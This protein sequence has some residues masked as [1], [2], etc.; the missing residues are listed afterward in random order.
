M[1]NKNKLFK[2]LFGLFFSISFSAF[3]AQPKGDPQSEDDAQRARVRALLAR[4]KAIRA[5]VAGL[6]L[7]RTQPKAF[8]V[9]VIT[10]PAT[11]QGRKNTG[12]SPVALRAE[13]SR[14]DEPIFAE[15]QQ[16]Q[17]PE[18]LVEGLEEPIAVS[19]AGF[20][21]ADQ[22][23]RSI[24]GSFE[25]PKRALVDYFGTSETPVYRQ[26]HKSDS[27]LF[28]AQQAIQRSLQNSPKQIC[29]QLGKLVEGDD[30]FQQRIV[31]LQQGS[32]CGFCALLN[33]NQ[34]VREFL[35]VPLSIT[36]DSDEV[37][38]TVDLGPEALQET[39]N[40]L[41]AGLDSH[42]CSN[43]WIVGS[44]LEPVEGTTNYN[45]Y[46]FTN[47]IGVDINVG[48]KTA[49]DA[50]VEH[51]VDYLKQCLQSNSKKCAV[52]FVINTVSSY[53]IAHWFTL[54]ITQ[55]ESGN[56][57]Y[58]VANSL[59]LP[60]TIVSKHQNLSLNGYESGFV[61]NNA[62]MSNKTV[63]KLVRLVEEKMAQFQ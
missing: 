40:M 52:P 53:H 8:P 18:L 17:E 29:G 35:N 50:V 63:Q 43:V 33:I 46:N 7:Q 36:L 19:L 6:S 4:G 13:E 25:E 39:W 3:S 60:S 14:W 54:V 47:R 62:T 2:L 21:G 27:S 31:S 57:Q 34:I 10:K 59:G 42:N 56:R 5:K 45:I 24:P 51:V 30:K 12:I 61:C 48:G 49:S 58:I 9:E 15:W 41:S 16:P 37:G 55:D 11:T 28:D 1:E 23:S 32:E 20:Y 44:Q 22:S 38:S 26:G